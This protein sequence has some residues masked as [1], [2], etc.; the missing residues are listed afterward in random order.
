[1]ANEPSIA[2]RSM[3]LDQVAQ[4]KAD[5]VAKTADLK[6]QLLT[7]RDT[8]VT[9]QPGDALAAHPDLQSYQAVEG[10]PSLEVIDHYRQKDNQD[11]IDNQQRAELRQ[12]QREDTALASDADLQTLWGQTKQA[13]G[14]AVQGTTRVVGNLLSAPDTVIADSAMQRLDAEALKVGAKQTQIEQQNR[15]IEQAKQAAYMDRFLGRLNQAQQQQRLA[16]LDEQA[17]QVPVL[18]PEDQAVLDRPARPLVT[19]AGDRAPSDLHPSTMG[20]QLKLVQER[21]KS[22][23]NIADRVTNGDW[24]QG[25]LNPL[26]RQKLD[27]DLSQN[28]KDN[29]ASLTSAKNA[30]SQDQYGKAVVDGA[31]GIA[32]LAIDGGKS[33]YQNPAALFEYIAENTPQLAVGAVSRPLLA[34]TNLAYGQDV[35]RQ[36]LADYQAKNKGALPSQNE[37]AAMLGFSLSASAAEHVMDGQL[38]KSF[39]V[40]RAATEAVGD[41]AAQGRKGVMGRL[42]GGAAE[43]GA[44]VAKDTAGE[45]LTEGYQTAVENNLSKLNT[46]IN[47]EDIY[48]AAVIGGAVGGAFGGTGE[49]I[50]QV[51]EGVHNNQAAALAGATER[52]SNQAEESRAAEAAQA[53]DLSGYLD[54]SKP[55]YSPAKALGTL[56]DQSKQADASDEVRAANIE[57]ANK[58]VDQAQTHLERV[59]QAYESSSP[60]ELARTKEMLAQLREQHDQ[61]DPADTV[62]L[63]E[64]QADIKAFEDEIAAGEAL[65]AEARKAQRL[66]L[67]KLE[68]QVASAQQ[69]KT[70]LEQLAKPADD[71]ITAQVG[72]ADTTLDEAAPE[73]HAQVRSAVDRVITLAMATPDALSP[74]M[75]QQL[76]DNTRNS[77]TEPQRQFLRTL[78]R[79]RVL[80]NQLKDMGSVNQD[81]LF[82]N[83]QTGYKGI[84]DY[85]RTITTALQAGN[86]RFAKQ[87]AVQLQRFADSHTQKAEQAAQILASGQG[88]Q[89]VK[90]TNGTWGRSRTAL[91]AKALRE[92]GGLQIH[93][94]SSQLVEGLQ[95]ESEALQ[96]AAE[97]AS[98]V[99]QVRS[100]KAQPQSVVEQA[101][102]PTV[103][104]KQEEVAAAEP[105]VADVVAPAPSVEPTAPNTSEAAPHIDR[106]DGRIPFTDAPVDGAYQE[107]NL[108][109]SYFEQVSGKNVV[110]KRPL[111]EVSDLLVQIAAGKVQIQD[112]LDAP[113]TE[114]QMTVWQQF[115][116]LANDWQS[117]IKDNLSRQDNAKFFYNDYMQFLVNAEG[118]LD[119]NV[120]TALSYAAFSWVAE[121]AND[122]FNNDEAINGILDRDDDAQVTDSM[123]SLLGSIGTRDRVIVNA[124]GQRVVQALGMRAK[125]D[126]PVNEQARLTSALGAHAL[127]LLLEEGL[128]ERSMVPGSELERFSDR[129]FTEGEKHAKHFFVRVARVAEGHRADLVPVAERIVSS[130]Q[131]TQGVLGKVFSTQETL[132]EP[133]YKPVPYSQKTTRNT[134]QKVPAVQAEILAKE[135]AKPHFVRQDMLQVLGKLDPSIIASAAG[136][137]DLAGVRKHAV[138][139]KGAQ[140][141]NESLQREIDRFNSYVETLANSPEGLDQALYFPHVAWKNQRVGID[142]NVLNPQTSKI[143]RHLVAMAGWKTDIALNDQAMVDTFLLRV[144]EGFGVKTDKQTNAVSL[145]EVHAVIEQPV[146]KQAVAALDKALYG[147]LLSP[148]EQ[149]AVLA[150]VKA[151]GENFH[152]L[153]ALVGLAQYEHARSQGD[154]HFTTSLMGE[155][156]GITNGPMLGHLQMGAAA[157]VDELMNTLHRGG[158]YEQGNETTQYGAWRGQPG[159][160][161]LYETS[162]KAMNDVLAQVPANQRDVLQAVFYITGML[163]KDDGSV[164]KD[165]RNIIKTPLTALVYGSSLTAAIDSMADSFIEK[166]YAHIEDIANGKQAK[167]LPEL[168]SAVKSL[169]AGQNQRLAQNIDPSMSIDQAL[170][171]TLNKG[172]V[173][174]LKAVFANTVG[175]SVQTVMERDFAPFMEARKTFNQAAQLSFELWNAAHT[176]MRQQMLNEL[177]DS[178]EIP[179]KTEKGQ[180]V[181]LHDLTQAQEKELRS[182]LKALEPVMHTVMSKASNDLGAGMFL[183]KSDRKLSDAVA[184]AN[185]VKFGRQI[186]QND[187]QHPGSAYASMSTKGYAR[188]HTNP[189]V[190]AMIG[191]IHSSDSAISSYAYAKLD[192]LNVHDAHGLGLK[193]IHAGARN[194]NEQTYQVMLDYSAPAEIYAALERTVQGAAALLADETVP[195]SVKTSMTAALEQFQ[196]KVGKLPQGRGVTEHVLEQTRLMAA[197][198]DKI[199]LGVLARLN[200]VDQYGFEGGAYQVSDADRAKAEQ[201]QQ[202]VVPA[203]SEQIRQHAKALDADTPK[204]TTSRASDAPATSPWGELGKA[205]LA[206]DAGLVKLFGQHPELKVGQLVSH[207]QQRLATPSG[208]TEAFYAQAL[209]AISQLVDPNMPVHYITAAGAPAGVRGEGVQLARAWYQADAQGEA[210]NVKSPDFV[211]SGVTV[212]TMMHELVHASVAKTIAKEREQLAQNPNYTSEALLSISELERLRVKAAEV[213]GNDMR[214]AN[215]VSSVDELVAWGMTNPAFQREVLNKVR[216][217]NKASKSGLL[218]GVKAFVERL[219]DILF[220]GSSQT[221][222]DK[223]YNGM[224]NLVSHSVS[225]MQQAKIDQ[226]T[227]AGVI[228][229]KQQDPL[230]GFTTEQIYEALGAQANRQVSPRFDAHLRGVLAGVVDKLYGPFGAYRAQAAA[231]Q[232][233]SAEDVYLKALATGQAPFASKTLGAGFTINEQEAFVLE[234]VEVTVRTALADSSTH[235]AYK[236]LAKLFEEARKTLKPSDFHDGDWNS[237]TT[238]EKAIAQQQYDHIFQAEQRIDGRSDYLSRFAAM[239]LAHEGFSQLLGFETAQAGA[240]TGRVSAF[241]RIAQL[242]EALMSAIVG[243]L[244]NTRAGQQADEK[245][246]ALVGQLVA[247]EARK[248]QVI[249]SRMDKMSAAV[250]DQL[251][252][253]SEKVLNVLDRVGKSKLL[254]QSKSGYL[255]A[256]GGVLSAVAGDR[257]DQIVDGLERLRDQSFKGRHGLLASLFNEA[258]GATESNQVFHVLLRMAKANEGQRKS[259]MTDTGNLVLQSYADQGRSL[260][261]KDKNALARVLLRTDMQALVDH[262]SPS[263]LL[264]LVSYGKELDKAIKGFE[265]QL[266]GDANLHYYLRSAKALGYF[267]ATGKVTV[268]N[269][270]MNVGNIASLFGTHRTGQVDAATVASVSKVLDPLVSLYALQYTGSA[271]KQLAMD[272]MRRELA[273]GNESGVEMTLGLHRELQKESAE[274]LFD[275]SSALMAKG[276][277]PEIFNPYKEVVVAGADQGLELERQGYVKGVKVGKDSA[278]MD[279]EPK[280]LYTI[281]DKGLAPY[282]TG[283][284]SYTGRQAKGST[285]HDGL[286]STAGKLREDSARAQSQ[287]SQ[288]KQQQ[289]RDMFADSAAF[290]P[291]AQ[292]ETFMAPVVNPA[293][294]VV[295]YRYL[296]SE[297]NKDSLLDRTNSFDKLMGS[298]AGSI[299]DKASTP[300]QNADAV[301]ALRD[302]YLA[303]YSQRPDSYLTVGPDSRDPELR[304]VWQM[305]PHDTRQDIRKIWGGNSMMVRADLVD[306]NFGYRKRSVSEMFDKDPEQRQLAERMLVTMFEGV[307]QGKGAL[308]A[309]QAEGIWQGM[310]RE[311]K[312]LMVVKNFRTLMG[313][314]FS[315]LSALVWYGVPPAQLIRDQRVALMGALSYRRDSTAAFQLRQQIAIGRGTPEMQQR[316]VKLEDAIRRNPVRELIE[317]GLLPTIV[318]DFEDES[319]DYGYKTKLAR[320]VDAKSAGVPQ[321]VKTAAKWVYMAHDTPLYKFMNQATQLGDFVS[322]YA[323]YQHLT[324]RKRNPMPRAEALQAASDTFVNYD[325]PT[326]RD[327]QYLNDMGAV[328]FSKYYIR[329]QKVI[330]RLYKAHPARALSL[331][332]FDNFVHNSDMLMDAAAIHKLGNPLNTGALKYPGLVDDLPTVQAMMYPFK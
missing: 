141:K 68:Q 211:H 249:E 50:S 190:A 36:A 112:Y 309:R 48:K 302:Q 268:P 35:Y 85:R 20:D 151:G 92:N 144:G 315:N 174:A 262:F 220:A 291:D 93:A 133:S 317:A 205:R 126:A 298:M 260:T 168:L 96:A 311:T 192:A 175:K 53:G 150:G 116:Q 253:V 203:L 266:A 38:L 212:E 108:V 259:V 43:V 310:V 283:I 171:F 280:H 19:A 261:A 26:N 147:D 83:S 247:I 222:R 4:Q 210:I 312:D 12:A 131:G 13:A 10:S 319:N 98:S 44:G 109:A 263:R 104:P 254:R 97:W 154:E 251:K 303:E 224:A 256:A 158:F 229:L 218:S 56:F 332:A 257:V 90:R 82:G 170:E 136:V 255:N 32:N 252:G 237:A 59:Q 318:E 213:A 46:D 265:Q 45:A 113:M 217:Q 62:A 306:I 226:Q 276:Y 316:L 194:L 234:Q 181:A 184:Y 27:E 55:T 327:M 79:S 25:L 214:F 117:T 264:E 61:I 183:S 24:A 325:I 281:S 76:A 70:Q 330:A 188:E 57:Q 164:S 166:I 110:T 228:T 328:M 140:A 206:S 123:R 138:N 51:R 180:R 94:G 297:H 195:A 295:N 153:D 37:A 160:L 120:K 232:A 223:L 41:A 191:S 11:Y 324:T 322:K 204:Q 88:G 176:A 3:M 121:N 18:T 258:R 301:Q 162:A 285:V 227:A 278:D 289:V 221:K 198:A 163:A 275:G 182:R 22:A 186:Q 244:T 272:V 89:L 313:N 172:Q 87:Q 102:A 14:A 146:V 71:D 225:L 243:K 49:S 216:I 28:W 331:V 290:N 101:P 39:G 159:N 308:R 294:Q 241:E 78:A 165:G 277:T 167:A 209:K 239:G 15:T 305:L 238:T 6:R 292:A 233:T 23:N 81:V 293:G 304:R 235:P 95:A 7:S 86:E 65:P 284:F 273:R 74:E 236:E 286:F 279:R 103:E 77:L 274:R 139:L 200:V 230:T 329:I 219:T 127:A 207:L 2:G 21:M 60:E 156:D 80:E 323:L 9:R 129:T 169:V 8:L 321:S 91:S 132:K 299:F 63:A 269:L 115:S 149:Q 75:A 16:G 326:H 161:D 300:E 34:A 177:M 246:Q 135:N 157:S 105:V 69:V 30:L 288:A 179:H 240:S 29:A 282:L 287:V 320:W 250:E 42:L 199:R 58:I 245:L 67:D 242:F 137:T 202:Q 185:N 107:K 40:G 31:K 152:T 17:S 208:R 231:L 296:M 99:Q 124:L 201:L 100:A 197:K 52:A 314:L 145:P 307:F 119:A 142:S 114:Q 66:Q 178:G 143:H 106:A 189:G 122:S 193:D 196:D 128:V 1:M 125:A 148:A 84:Q 130:S 33:V 271:D 5:T 73:Q 270:M 155:V 118:D 72:L 173:Q 54:P 134:D 64:S 248:R 111:V 267:K 215:A 187:R 47:G